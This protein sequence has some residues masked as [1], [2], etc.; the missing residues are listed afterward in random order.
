MP[1]YDYKCKNCGEKYTRVKSIHAKTRRARCPK[2]KKF[3]N[4]KI[5]TP[6]FKVEGGTPKFYNQ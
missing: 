5:G 2:C 1:R 4:P 3:N 6:N